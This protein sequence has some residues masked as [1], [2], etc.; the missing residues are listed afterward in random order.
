MIFRIG[1]KVVC[2]KASGFRRV[3]PLTKGAVYTVRDIGPEPNYKD[4]QWVLLEEVVNSS[5]PELG[6]LAYDAVRFRP[7]VERK[8]DISAFKKMLTPQGVEA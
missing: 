4:L 6:E 1:Q 5:D 7:A 2:V 8:T 3:K